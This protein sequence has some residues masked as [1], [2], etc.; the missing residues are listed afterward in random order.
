[1]TGPSPHFGRQPQLPLRTKHQDPRWDIIDSDGSYGGALG[2]LM[3]DGCV[4]KTI[5]VGK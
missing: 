2:L 1:M 3:G 5:G 4:T